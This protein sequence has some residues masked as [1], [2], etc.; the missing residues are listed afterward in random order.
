MT[1]KQLLKEARELISSLFN[2]NEIKLEENKSIDVKYNGSYIHIR[3]T[4]L[5]PDN[6]IEYSFY[7]RK[8]IDDKIYRYSSFCYDKKMYEWNEKH[9]YL[10]PVINGYYYDSKPHTEFRKIKKNMNLDYLL[11]DYKE[12]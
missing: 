1:K 3:N 10:K 8:I 6:I 2:E 5:I 9:T 11:K 12:L 7:Y 4:G